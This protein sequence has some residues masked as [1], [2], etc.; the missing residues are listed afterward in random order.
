[1]KK[2]F[3]AFITT[4]LLTFN[5]FA[6]LEQPCENTPSW[7]EKGWNAS[8]FA[9]LLTTENNSDFFTGKTKFEKS[10]PIGVGVGK[11]ITPILDDQLDFEMESQLVQHTGRQTHQ[12]FQPF[13]FIF[14]WLDFPWNDSLKTSL[15]VGDGLSVAT[16]KPKLEVKKRGKKKSNAPLNYVLIELTFANPDTPEWDAFLR[17]HH[18]SGMFGTYNN[19]WDASTAFMLGVKRHF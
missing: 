8:L 16:E 13:V 9:G 11:Q 7:W 5:G 18:R 17:Y 19:T 14:R 6:E 12:E 4:T 1:M 2:T 10:Y 3:S 15:A